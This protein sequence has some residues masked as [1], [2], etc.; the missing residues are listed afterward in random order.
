MGMHIREQPISVSSSNKKQKTH[1]ID[2]RFKPKSIRCVDSANQVEIPP[3]AVVHQHHGRVQEL[4]TQPET[5]YYPV[6]SEGEIFSSDPNWD[7]RD[8]LTARPATSSLIAD[9]LDFMLA[10]VKQ[11]GDDMY[12]E[13]QAQEESNTP[14]SSTRQSQMLGEPEVLASQCLETAASATVQPNG[15]T[16]PR[17][18]ESSLIESSGQN[19]LSRMTVGEL[20]API[21]VNRREPERTSLMVETIQPVSMPN[22][23]MVDAA[24][25]LPITQKYQ[26]EAPS[27]LKAAPMP[28][29]SNAL[30]N[31]V[32][33]GD[34][35]RGGVVPPPSV[36]QAFTKLQND[37]EI[38]FIVEKSDGCLNE[39]SP[40][41]P[42]EV[43]SASLE[44][45]L[46]LVADRRTLPT[47]P[48]SIVKLTFVLDWGIG[49]RYEVPRNTS[50]S[51]W[52]D[53]KKKIKKTVRFYNRKMGGTI[54]EFQIHVEVVVENELRIS[55]HG[56]V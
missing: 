5:Q 32:E 17:E 53:M 26:S 7:S 18:P 29:N 49:E 4:A 34:A 46:E 43:D 25:D 47:H 50:P 55:Y 12:A 11:E 13:R 31:V 48:E 8:W 44:T 38:W 19:N 52:M 1:H 45:F 16:F 37:P 28:Q 21:D 39:D 24:S 51:D 2:D 33:R 10:N 3:A 22:S 54:E 23:N 9:G 27:G 15:T 14:L 41:S 30:H 42:E 40:I 35:A 36:I 6:D 56:W 20:R